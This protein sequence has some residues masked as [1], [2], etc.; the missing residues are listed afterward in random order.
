MELNPK[1]NEGKLPA[2]KLITNKLETLCANVNDAC[3]RKHGDL[4][5]GMY[6][7]ADTLCGL[8]ELMAIPPDEFVS[9]VLCGVK[10]ARDNLSVAD[11]IQ[12]I[13][14]N[15]LHECL[16]VL[17]ARCLGPREEI[18]LAKGEETQPVD[19]TDPRD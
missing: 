15:R 18:A 5:T 10:A 11:A 13:F 9:V 7:S 14:W 16:G 8:L 1:M 4:A 6:A 12:V 17:D 19:R 3:V 2:H